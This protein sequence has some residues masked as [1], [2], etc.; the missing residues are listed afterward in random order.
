ML[1]KIIQL[2]VPDYL[3]DSLKL[4]SSVHEIIVVGLI[5]FNRVSEGGKS[6]QV[7]AI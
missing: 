3:I 1:Y 4:I 2:N 6:F 5:E 7:T